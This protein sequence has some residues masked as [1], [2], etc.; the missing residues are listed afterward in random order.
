M[1]T[2]QE[3]SEMIRE[4]DA[5]FPNDYFICFNDKLGS[6]MAGYVNSRRRSVFISIEDE[7]ES[8]KFVSALKERGVRVI[9]N[10]SELKSSTNIKD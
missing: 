7:G 5:E 6:S 1:Y 4:F 3:L 9:N 8:E 10:L 2:D